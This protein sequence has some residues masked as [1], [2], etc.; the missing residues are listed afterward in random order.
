[1]NRISTT[2]LI[3]STLLF[4]AC[5]YPDN[6]QEVALK[7]CE[8]TKNLDLSGMRKYATKAYGVNLKRKMKSFEAAL[9]QEDPKAIDLK[10]RYS[11]ISCSNLTLK[12]GMGR[13]L[14]VQSTSE[15]INKMRLQQIN[16]E[17]KV[18]Q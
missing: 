17:W 3:T 16:R 8:A 18:I 15:V 4:T 2:L 14:H 12:E 13:I 7:M 6:P 5:D 1:M 9:D 11:Q 10:Q